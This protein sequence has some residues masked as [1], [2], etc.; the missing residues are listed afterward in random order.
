M[1]DCLVHRQE[2]KREGY[3]YMNPDHIATASTA[4][5]LVLK[6]LFLLME[7]VN[8][9]ATGICLALI[10]GFVFHRGMI[11]IA[12]AMTGQETIRHLS[13]GRVQKTSRDEAFGYFFELA[14]G[15]FCALMGVICVF[16]AA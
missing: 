1:V 6:A 9:S 16:I 8:I 7:R 4:C 3:Y 13:S 10:F 12:D 15:I 14:F 11:T 2:D 5:L